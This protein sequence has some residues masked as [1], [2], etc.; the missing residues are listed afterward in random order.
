MTSFVAPESW[1]DVVRLT[2]GDGLLHAY[3]MARTHCV[4]FAPGRIELRLERGAPA[5]VAP[6]LSSTLRTLTDRAWVIGLCWANGE[7]TLVEQGKTEAAA[8]EAAALKHPTVEAVFSAWP[9]AKVVAFRDPGLDA[10]G[11]PKSPHPAQQA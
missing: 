8:R 11:L 9:E 5:W 7:P 3:L 6:R 10:Y 1:T 2:I 4:S